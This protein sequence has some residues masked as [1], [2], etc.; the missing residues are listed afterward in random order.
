[1][2]T[3]SALRFNGKAVAAYL[4][5]GRELFETFG[6]GSLG[7]VRRE[8]SR[9]HARLIRI[10]NHSFIGLGMARQGSRPA[11]RWQ[12]SFPGVAPMRWSPHDG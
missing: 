10:Q 5:S 9:T 2:L 12:A 11:R 4:Q 7:C 1:M 3:L 6:G 8:L